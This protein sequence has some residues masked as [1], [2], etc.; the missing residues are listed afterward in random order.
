M[1]NPSSSSFQEKRARTV[2]IAE[3]H[4]A[5]NTANNTTNITSIID[6]MEISNSKEVHTISFSFRGVRGKYS[7]EINDSGKPHGEGQFVRDTPGGL[8]YV[9]VWRD[10]ERVGNGGYYGSN[11]LVGIVVWE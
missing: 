2:S 1:Q 11:G 6:V 8:T 10:G 4:L 3:H 9:G 5:N 7:G